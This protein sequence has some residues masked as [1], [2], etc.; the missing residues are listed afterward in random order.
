M[1]EITAPEDE[2][3]DHWIEK[4]K[5][6][7][8][9]FITVV[10]GEPSLVLPRLKK[11]YDNFTINVA[12]NGLR[13]IPEI[14]FENLPI[15]VALWGNHKTD[16][17][18][19]ANGKRDLFSEAL[20]NYHNDERAFWYYTVAPGNADEIVEVTERCIANGNRVLYNYYSDLSN[21]GGELDYRNGFEKVMGEIDRMIGRYPDKILSTSYL[22]HTIALGDLF[23]QH[24]GYN[25]CT[26]L[27][28]NYPGNSER[29]EK[30]NPINPHFRAYNADF[31]TTRRCCTGIHR[32]CESCFDTWEHF[33]WIM[34]NLRKHLHSREDFG[35]WLKTVYIFYLINNLVRPKDVGDILTRIHSDTESAESFIENAF[36]PC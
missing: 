30:G 1:D 8:T 3:I 2:T 12:T 21:L 11:L 32:D 17:I 6:R 22:N 23:D 10:G 15:G 31:A 19:R 4:E 20:R 33:S 7:G 13:K 25:V 35:N 29:I 16:S 36:S 24:W 5:E 14:G 9:N 28:E 26:N 18:L 27:S 34:I